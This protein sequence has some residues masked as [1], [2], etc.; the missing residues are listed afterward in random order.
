M[1]Y[2]RVWNLPTLIANALSIGI[3]FRWNTHADAAYRPI[4]TLVQYRIRYLL[5]RVA[6]V[7]LT[8]ERDATCKLVHEARDLHCCL[9]LQLD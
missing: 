9:T 5:P 4:K 6:P 8:Q 7:M 1:S 2:P 3:S